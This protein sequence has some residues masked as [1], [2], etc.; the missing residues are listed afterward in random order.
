MTGITERLA[1]IIENDVNGEIKSAV[2]V[3]Q[4]DVMMILS[5]Y[6]DVTKLNMAV[7]KCA[8]GYTVTI[9]AHA[10]RIFGVGNISDTE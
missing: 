7:D 5:E 6:M 9:T 2:K 10:S 1:R 8:D 3:A 4:S